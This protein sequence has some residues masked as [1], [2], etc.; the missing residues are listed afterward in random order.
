MVLILMYLT[1]IFTIYN[2]VAKY[3]QSFCDLEM[4]GELER[5]ATFQAGRVDCDQ[6]DDHK[7][8]AFSANLHQASRA[9]RS[10]MHR[11]SGIAVCFRR[12]SPVAIVS[13]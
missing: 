5:I 10:E 8:Q 6:L 1:S 2:T 12:S 7:A 4:R 13:A 9:L 3:Q 11:S